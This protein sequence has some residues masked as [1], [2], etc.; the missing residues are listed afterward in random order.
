[1]LNGRRKWHKIKIFDK[2]AVQKVDFVHHLERPAETRM[3][4]YRM[5]ETETKYLPNLT[6]AYLV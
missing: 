2:K 1:M 6:I 5:G 4:M 3:V